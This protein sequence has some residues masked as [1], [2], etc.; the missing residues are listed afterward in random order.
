MLNMMYRIEY[1]PETTY[2]TYVNAENMKDAME[3]FRTLE[4]EGTLHSEDYPTTH[5]YRVT[6][7][8]PVERPDLLIDYRGNPTEIAKNNDDELTSSDN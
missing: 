1:S 3:K 7:F 8:V 5:E 2:V 6:H 4:N